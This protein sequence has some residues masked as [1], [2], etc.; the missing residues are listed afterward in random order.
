MERGTQW[1]SIQG[2]SPGYRQGI[3]RKEA[4]DS[5]RPCQDVRSLKG[6]HK[7]QQKAEYEGW[8]WR[9]MSGR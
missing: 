3:A 9:T 1:L 2:Q 7:D 8:K 6:F 4:L 5:S